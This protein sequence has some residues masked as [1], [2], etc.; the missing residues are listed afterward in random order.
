MCHCF[1]AHSD[2]TQAPSRL[3]DGCESD[4]YFSFLA[5]SAMLQHQR[6]KADTKIDSV[7]INA[8]PSS[9]LK[10]SSQMFYE[11]LFIMDYFSVDCFTASPCNE[12]HCLFPGMAFQVKL[13]KHLNYITPF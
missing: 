3:N 5:S 7:L 11:V 8:P 2:I 10:A 6:N 9:V 4:F 13:K 12:L 1:E